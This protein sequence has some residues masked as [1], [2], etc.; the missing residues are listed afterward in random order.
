MVWVPSWLASLAARLSLKAKC[1]TSHTERVPWVQHQQENATPPSHKQTHSRTPC[2]TAH[3]TCTPSLLTLSPLLAWRL[4]SDVH[5]D[6]NTTNA[7]AAAA[8][9]VVDGMATHTTSTGPASNATSTTT[10]SSSTSSGTCAVTASSCPV[11]CSP[12]SHSAP[13][14]P[15]P[16]P[17]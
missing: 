6:A 7:A 16:H 8:A 13:T 10:S 17:P 9:A 12:T 4:R 1:E 2:V 11:Y 5:L 14:C 15:S 3:S